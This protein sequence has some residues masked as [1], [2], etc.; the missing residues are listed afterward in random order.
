MGRVL[1]EIDPLFEQATQQG[2]LQPAPPRARTVQLWAS[3]QGLLQMRKLGRLEP[4]LERIDEL[5]EN[6]TD[7][8]LLGWGAPPQ[9]LSNARQKL[10]GN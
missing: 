5:V 9:E 1:S 3:L 6:T 2:L 7:T 4:V 8:L 10:K